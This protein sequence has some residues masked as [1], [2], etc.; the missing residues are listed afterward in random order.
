MDFTKNFEGI[1]E[2]P[3]NAV[4]Q[5][6]TPLDDVALPDGKIIV[7]IHKIKKNRSIGNVWLQYN[8]E[9]DIVIKRMIRE[10]IRGWTSE[11]EMLMEEI[12]RL[13]QL[14]KKPNLRERLAITRLSNKATKLIRD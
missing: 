14:F 11:V 13:T 10:V 1:I 3:E 5:I 12:T 8:N 7:T 6:E 9:Q 4:F 2:S